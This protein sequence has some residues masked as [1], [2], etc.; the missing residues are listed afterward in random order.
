MQDGSG[1]PYAD[2]V[3][4]DTQSDSFAAPPVHVL[5]ENED[6]TRE[7]AEAQ[8]MRQAN[9][10]LAARA[11]GGKGR[12]VGSVA[13]SLPANQLGQMETMKGEQVAASALALKAPELGEG[14]MLTLSPIEFDVPRCKDIV[15][16]RT[17]GFALSMT[18]R[19]QPAVA[20]HK[21]AKVPES[22]NCPRKYGLSEAYLHTPA[23]GPPAIAV[24]VEIYSQGFEGPDRRFLAITGRL[25]K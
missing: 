8:A 1:F 14:A 19:G 11:I 22:R 6:A 23:G 13:A 20:L 25:A 3:V 5:L 9:P 2:V 15:E 7:Q 12:L 24:L 10:A 17:S 18:R 21:D 4:I 16:G